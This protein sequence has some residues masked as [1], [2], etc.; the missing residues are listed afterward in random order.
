MRLRHFAACLVCTAATGL[1]SAGCV[2]HAV[3]GRMNVGKP[4]NNTEL[5]ITPGL[6]TVSQLFEDVGPPDYIIDGSRRLLDEEAFFAA[7][8]RGRYDF[9]T[10]QRESTPVSTRVLTAPEGEVILVY[11]A[12][13]FNGRIL[14]G[15]NV[16][17]KLEAA[18]SKS[19]DVLIFVDKLSRTVV[20]AVATEAEAQK[21]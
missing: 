3:A 2:S 13:A 14:G 11:A 16:P 4:L 17:V 8:S 9:K 18:A 5:Q 20:G 15:G 10:K 19:G 6:T 21:P 7:F 12:T 1:L